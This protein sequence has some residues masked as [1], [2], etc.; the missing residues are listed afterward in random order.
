VQRRFII[1]LGV[2]RVHAPGPGVAAETA[3]PAGESAPDLLE[4]I[5]VQEPEPRF[6]APTRRD[7]IGR[8]WAPV[9][10]N[11]KGPFRLVLDTGSNRSC[12]NA[13]VAAAL[14]MPMATGEPVVLRGITGLRTV[15]TI[16]VDS[17]VAGELDLHS[18][19]LPI[20]TD[21]LGGADGVLG[22]EGLQDKRIVID[23]RHDL[24]TIY[25]SHG[26]RAPP[27]FL[28]IPVRIVNGLLMIADVR[29]GSLRAKAIIDTGGQGTIANSVLRDALARRLRSEDITPSEVTGTTLDVQR[30][31]LVPTPVITIGDLKIRH[32]YITAGDMYIFQ[33]W[34]MTREP[35]V[36]IGMDLLGLFDKLIIDYKRREL[37]V[38]MRGASAQESGR[39]GNPGSISFR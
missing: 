31:D 23:F 36:L 13:S 1:L 25:R 10:I 24:I 22:T 15:P 11:G 5:V 14:G 16:A 33:Y 18:K 21:A 12:V 29:I 26:Q 37:Q 28:T 3:P 30:G 34:G 7:R 4:E 27:G 32:A 35:A 19:R 17:L 38:L 20:V 8:I 6:V 9:L 2:L 39:F